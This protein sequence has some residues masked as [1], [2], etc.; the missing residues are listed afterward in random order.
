MNRRILEKQKIKE[1]N[2]ELIVL[3]FKYRNIFK[4]GHQSYKVFKNMM[5][6]ITNI[7]KKTYIRNL[8]ETMLSRNIFKIKYINK[9]RF[10]IFNPYNLNDEFIGYTRN[11]ENK[12]IINF[13]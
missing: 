6:Y 3:Y 12:F 8:F 1:N 9:S 13:N 4:M 10:Y 7:E 5:I 11:N 2:I